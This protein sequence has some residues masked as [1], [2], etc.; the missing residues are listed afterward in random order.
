MAHAQAALLSKRGSPFPFRITEKTKIVFSPQSPPT[1]VGDL[2]L[3]LEIDLMVMGD[4]KSFRRRLVKALNTVATIRL[5]Q[6]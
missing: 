4:K 3:M 1:S 5:R 2:A 6:S